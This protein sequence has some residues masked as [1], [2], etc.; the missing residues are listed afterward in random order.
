MTPEQD[1]PRPDPAPRPR[2][3]RRVVR[4]GTEREQ[5]AGVSQDERGGHD[6]NDDRLLR[7]VPPHWGRR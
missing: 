3:H 4:E 1:R 7:D 2:K 5:V 6:D